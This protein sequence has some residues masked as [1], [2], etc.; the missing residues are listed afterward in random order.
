MSFVFVSKSEV[1]GLLI[2]PRSDGIRRVGVLLTNGV[3]SLE[4][5]PVD[6][7]VKISEWM[8]EELDMSK[9][10]A[11]GESRDREGLAKSIKE[12]YSYLNYI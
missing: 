3:P 4:V 6:N 7:L 5:D 8:F 1:A 12:Y 11:A 9:R 10:Q 2:T